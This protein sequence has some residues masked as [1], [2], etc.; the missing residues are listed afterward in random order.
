MIKDCDK[1]NDNELSF[2][3]FNDLIKKISAGDYGT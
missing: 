3:E 2:A 1:N